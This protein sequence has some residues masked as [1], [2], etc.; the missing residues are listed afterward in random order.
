ME[1]LIEK[2]KLNG[3]TEEQAE[4]SIQTIS[5]WLNEYYPVAGVLVSS[6]IKVDYS[7]AP[8]N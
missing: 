5:D 2:M 8:K 7:K 3:L 1:E 6:W 4:N